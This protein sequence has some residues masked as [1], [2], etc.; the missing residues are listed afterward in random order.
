MTLAL[1]LSDSAENRGP[2]SNGDL[3]VGTEL[4]REDNF[5]RGWMAQTQGA[6]DA[7][8]DGSRRRSLRFAFDERSG[9]AQQDMRDKDVVPRVTEVPAGGRRPVQFDHRDAL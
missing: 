5:A 8:M 9:L 7:L 1:D 3:E 6:P 4:W 2:A